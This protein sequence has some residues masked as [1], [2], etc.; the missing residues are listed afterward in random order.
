Q[1]SLYSRNQ[2]SLHARSPPIVEALE[3][4]Q[5][6]AVLDGEVVALDDRGRAQFQLLQNYQ[7]TGRG[8]LACYVFDLLYV[9]G[10]DLRGLPLTRRK[11]VLSQVVR[12][13]PMV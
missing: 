9:D 11:E 1:V 12:G 4:L 13:L 7:T 8:Q 2:K 6:D 10:R 3:K 5:H